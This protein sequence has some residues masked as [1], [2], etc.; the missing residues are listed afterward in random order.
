MLYVKEDIETTERISPTKQKTTPEIKKKERSFNCLQQ[1]LSICNT[2]SQQ[3][4]PQ[5]SVMSRSPFQ[6]RL[7]LQLLGAIF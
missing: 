1:I 4:D 5:D 2:H 6:I 3:S 7:H